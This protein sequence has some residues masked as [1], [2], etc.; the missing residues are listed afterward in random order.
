ML[1][2][3]NAAIQSNFAGYANGIAGSETHMSAELKSET[4]EVAAPA[5]VKAWRRPPMAVTTSRYRPEPGTTKMRSSSSRSCW[6]RRM[7][8]FS[9]LRTRTASPAAKRS[10]LK[11]AEVAAA[12]VKA[13]FTQTCSEQAIKL[14]DRVW[15]KL[16]Q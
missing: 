7:R 10:E 14:A 2:P 16:M 12:D 11:S 6:T 15:T 1:D 9:P 5:D 4:P 8:R 3:E 13:V